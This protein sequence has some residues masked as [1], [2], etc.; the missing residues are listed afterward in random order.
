MGTNKE[1]FRKIL[2]GPQ[3]MSGYPA[4]LSSEVP[5]LEHVS[6]KMFMNN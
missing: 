2:P 5:E 1:V 6:F 3:K 4:S